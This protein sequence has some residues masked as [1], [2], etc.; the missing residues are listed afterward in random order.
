MAATFATSRRGCVRFFRVCRDDR[1]SASLEL[2]IGAVV[3]L[4]VAALAFDLHSL[5]KTH[6]GSARIAATMA[7]YVSR[8]AAPNGDDLAALGEF[9]YREEISAPAALVY[10]VWAVHQ[11]PG[12][13]PAV[14]LWDDDT[15][16]FGNTDA[17]A[18]LVQQC[19]NIGR[20]GWQKTLLGEE[21]NSLTLA[22]DDVVIVVEVCTRLMLQGRLSNRFI[23]GTI[24]RLHALPMRDK[25]QLPSPPAHSPGHEAQ[26]TVLIDGADEGPISNAAAHPAWAAAMTGTV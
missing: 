15:I 20:E 26:T 13:N 14:R 25:R 19:R 7:E 22:D 10:V 1:A 16:R 23:A 5:V 8:E 12:G 6:T 2:G 3:V 18:D 24:Y 21:D 11:P 4:V 9:L 17:T